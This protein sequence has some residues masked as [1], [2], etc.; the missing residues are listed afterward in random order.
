ML[1]IKLLLIPIFTLLISLPFAVTSR[2]V[3]TTLNQNDFVK[4]V[5]DGKADLA[6]NPSAQKD[7]KDSKDSE[8]ETANDEDNE[9]VEDKDVQET[10]E[11]AEPAESDESSN[12]GSN[13]GS[14]TGNSSSSNP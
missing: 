13:G 6:N 7:V 9:A 5:N 1:P 2:A 4:D 8:V 10:P 14:E 12:E 3:T 11:Q